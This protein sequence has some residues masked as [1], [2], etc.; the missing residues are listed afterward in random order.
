MFD[1]TDPNSAPL[2]PDSAQSVPPHAPAVLPQGA[3]PRPVVPP[4]ASQTEKRPNKP[5]FP[6]RPLAPRQMAA[7]RLIIAGH[8]L[9]EI[10]RALEIDRKTLFRWTRSGAFVEEVQKQHD[11]LCREA[12]KARVLRH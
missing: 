6:P 8:R 9:G 7:V 3:P 10:C 4:G 1:P 11:R 2:L 5:K 12:F